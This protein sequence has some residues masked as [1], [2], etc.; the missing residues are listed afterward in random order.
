MVIVVIVVV[1]MVMVTGRGLT[2]LRCSPGS[3]TLQSRVYLPT[4]T[5]NL[6]WS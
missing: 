6:L 1:V 2:A 4:D 5:L 3:C